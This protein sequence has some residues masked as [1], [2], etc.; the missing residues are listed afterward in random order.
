MGP[1]SAWG[2][3]ELSQ[4]RGFF[5]CHLALTHNFVHLGEANAIRGLMGQPG[6]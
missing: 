2:R 1:A 6:R 5:L 3:S 4:T